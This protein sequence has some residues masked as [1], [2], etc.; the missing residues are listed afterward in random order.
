MPSSE[1]FGQRGRLL[2]ALVLLAAL[3]GLLVWYGTLPAYDSSMN[4][5]PNEDDV[6]PEPDAYVDQQVV[7]GGHVVDTEPVTIEVTTDG[8]SSTFTVHNA[9]E[10]L[11]NSDQSLESGDRVTAFG[12]LTD[13]STLEAERYST[14]EPWEAQYMY[15]VS[16]LGG[17]WVLGR[18]VRGWQFD[19]GRLAFVPRTRDPSVERTS[20][21]N[22]T[23][24]FDEENLEASDTP[25]TR[26]GGEQ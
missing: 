26:A 1:P 14:R 3:G 20:D 4:D 8:S 17:L 22:T 19:R 25:E 23:V 7:L 6:A 12:T 11:R 5:F 9:N 18:F 13:T 21:R 16:F 15:V 24:Q 2:C 10:A